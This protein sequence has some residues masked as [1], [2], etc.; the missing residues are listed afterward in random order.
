MREKSFTGIDGCRSG[1]IAVTGSS[2]ARARMLILGRLSDLDPAATLVAIDMPI[3]LP[4]QVAREC[5][6]AA[7]RLLPRGR[8]SSVF[9]VPRRALLDC[10]TY[11][12]ANKAS[13]DLFGCGLPKQS[14]NL[15]PKLRE[16]DSWALTHAQ[17]NI[18][19]AH[20][21][22]AFLRLNKGQPLP[23]KR[24]R[25]GLRIRHKVLERVGFK[26]LTKWVTA[27]PSRDAKADDLFDACALLT[28]AIRIG[29]NQAKCV[30][31]HC[32]RDAKGLR[33]EIWY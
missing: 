26:S 11:P 20:P 27:L 22:L 8:K 32:E 16:A 10:A 4:G 5:E 23:P 30:T 9:P 1:W 14:W 28:T 3:G 17:R 12:D 19:E 7:R 21:E 15:F 29:R 31:P 33:M 6:A 25:E 13:K 24:T 2:P 18:F